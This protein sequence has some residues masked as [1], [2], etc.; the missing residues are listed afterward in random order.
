MFLFLPAS[1]YGKP[2]IEKQI[3]ALQKSLLYPIKQNQPA[4]LCISICTNFEYFTKEISVF[5]KN[6]NLKN[7]ENHKQ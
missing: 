3:L 7:D 6:Y 4:Y 1:F 2:K 5:K